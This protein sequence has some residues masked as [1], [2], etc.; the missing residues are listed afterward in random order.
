MSEMKKKAGERAALFV[1]SNMVVGLGTGSTTAFA[2]EA[3]GNRLKKGEIQNIRGVPTSFQARVLAREYGI[4]LISM[5][6]VDR[7]HLAI[8]G[9]DEVDPQLNLIKGGG[10]AHT[11]EK[12]VDTF[13]D[14]FVVVVD[15]GKLVPRLGTTFRVPVEVIPMAYRSVSLLLKKLGGEAL[16]RMGVKKAGPVVT[17][18]GNLVLDV[19]F[20]S[21]ENLLSLSMEIN[22]IPGIVEHGLFVNAADVI[23]VGAMEEGLPVVREIYKA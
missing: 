12:I 19:C 22:H 6:E 15:E 17:D 10:A 23:V 14:K 8:D 11:L 18:S 4:P 21:M 16:L 20:E 1:E 9:A 5:E 3:I 2:I 7:I 13:A